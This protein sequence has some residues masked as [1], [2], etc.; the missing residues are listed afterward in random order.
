MQSWYLINS[1]SLTSGDESET[2]NAYKSDAINELL[3]NDIAYTVNV[4]NYDLSVCDEVRAIVSNKTQD[5][6]LKT[7]TRN[8]LFP[9]GTVIAGN[10]VEYEDK[11]W[12][13]TGLVD[14]NGVYEKAI[15]SICNYLLTWVNGYGNIVQR[16][17]NISS[18]SQY[19]NG[20]TSQTYYE[21]RTDQLMIQIPDDDESLMIKT[22]QRFIIDKR[23]NVFNKT[24]P[25]NINVATDFDLS[26]F[27]VSRLDSVLYDYQGSG[28][29]QFMA[30]QDEK[31]DND[32]FYRYGGVGYW[33]CDGDTVDVNVQ[34]ITKH[35][36]ILSEDD[37][38]IHYLTTYQSVYTAKYFND[39]GVEVS[40]SCTWSLVNCSFSDKVTLTPN[41]TNSSVSILA[42]DKSLS[43]KKITLK[44][45]AVGYSDAT[46]EITLR[47]I[48]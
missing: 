8:M 44:A 7:L 34:S 37:K 18:A 22:N 5:T 19:N 15:M 35:I 14:N 28:Y 33:I 13:V 24:I 26:V 9:I 36:E 3:A 46:K 43:G 25:Q 1:Q 4:Y 16:W 32:G 6:D 10:Y 11:M 23:I 40:G 47:N 45:S 30:Y 38:F 17:A 20:E 27:R 39:N 29:Y 2:Y 42:K 21:V 31:H 41:N 12:L 48:S